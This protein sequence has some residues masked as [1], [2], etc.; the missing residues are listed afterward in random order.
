MTHLLVQNIWLVPVYSLIGALIS[1]LWFPSV[2]RRTGPR[3]SGYV[4]AIM[5]LVSFIHSVLAFVA[6][7]H[8]PAEHLSITWLKVANL[9]LTLPIEVSS[10]TVGALVVITGINVLAQ[11]F[12]IG[13][14]EMDWGWARFYSLLALFEAGMCALVLCDSL[15]F[16]YMILEILTLATYLLVGLWFNQ[17]L[18][19][20]GARDAFLTKRIGDLLL[21]MGVL[22]V[23]PLAGTWDFSQLA[24]WAQTAQVDPKVLALVGIALIA[25]PMGKCA[26]FPLH[27]WLDEAMEGPLPAS[28]LRNS[29]VVATGA[30]VLIKLQPF[31]ALS[32]FVL[33]ATV[34]IGAVTALGGTLMA[35]AQIDIKRTLSYLVSAYMGLIFIA[36]GVQQTEAAFQLM[37]VHAIA[38]ALLMMGCG[39]VIW[40]C[41]TQDLRQFGGLW[42]RRPISGS[43]FIVG[44]A[45]LVALPPLGGFWGMLKLLEGLWDSHP[46]LVAL[47]IGVNA[48]A[49]FSLTRTFC[50]VWGGKPKPMTA[51]SPEVFW[52]M[53]LPT[54]I[55]MGFALHLPLLMQA[56]GL[57]PAWDS[58]Q[59]DQALILTGSTVLGCLVSA[60]VYFSPAIPKPVPV[61]KVVQDFLS[62]LTWVPSEAPGRRDPVMFSQPNG[63]TPGLYRTGVVFVINLVS[64]F[65]SWLDR[66]M[67]DGIVNLFGSATIF[68][69]QT[70]RYI[71]AGQSQ[72]YILTILLGTALIGIL[73]CW[74]VLAN[75]T[76]VSGS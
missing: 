8:Q 68:S 51:R 12:A 25:G 75:L 34:F 18:V 6:L 40:N 42:S 26:Q 50:L 73:L 20:A 9:N 64:E 39:N 54:V 62:Y 57:L 67:V 1:V 33:S 58:L 35:I 53:I 43:S 63:L 27:L 36:V 15:F 13:Y 22:G 71:T 30:W 74:P 76:L 17:A 44:A 16:A 3:P 56:T 31:L 55:M 48:T 11:I 21:L 41:V 19:I 65:T 61:P 14:L 70:L 47:L 7:N 24:V 2:I 38:M 72:F 46:L 66:N 28:I 52:P 49:A 23:Y 45:A 5:T 4:N 69:G 10:L 59:P 32:P 29:V 60:F 37:L